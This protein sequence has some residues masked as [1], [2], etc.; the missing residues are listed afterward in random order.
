MMRHKLFLSV[1]VLAFGAQMMG[2][3][4]VLVK[5][6]GQQEIQN[7]ATIGKWVYVGNDLQLISH[8]GEVLAQESVLE[9][10]KI[11]FAK[12]NTSTS[13]ENA[14]DKTIYIYPNPTQDVLIVNGIDTPVLR[15]FDMQGRLLKQEKGNQVSVGDLADGTYL[16]QVGTQ[17]TRFIKK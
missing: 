3:N 11:V 12:A 14:G 13:P 9:I 7:V 15:V 4:L 16:L 2:A 8:D 1:M 10:R 6:N 17:V 5:S